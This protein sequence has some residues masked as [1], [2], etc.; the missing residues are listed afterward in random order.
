M[1][2]QDSIAQQALDK[3]L[4]EAARQGNLEEIKHLQSIGANINAEIR[5]KCALDTALESKD[6]DTIRYILDNG[7]YSDSTKSDVLY[8]AAADGNFNIVT[9][10]INEYHIRDE[11]VAHIA[12]ENGHSNIMEFMLALDPTYISRGDSC[13]NTLMHIAV[14]EN[15][16]DLVELLLSKYKPDINAIASGDNVWS[17]AIN[18]MNINIIKQLIEYN[19][20]INQ[21]VDSFYQENALHQAL[22]YDTTL[23]VAELLIL[24]GAFLS[25]YN[26]HGNAPIHLLANSDEISTEDLAKM[27]RLLVEHGA[28]IDIVN[29]KHQTARDIIKTSSEKLQAFEKASELG[30][31]ALENKKMTIVSVLEQVSKSLELPYIPKILSEIIVDYLEIIDIHHKINSIGLLG[32]SSDE[33]REWITSPGFSDKYLVSNKAKN[34]QYA[35]TQYMQDQLRKII[36][37]VLENSYI[38]KHKLINYLYN[39]D[40]LEVNGI[41]GKDYITSSKISGIKSV[42]AKHPLE[43]DKQDFRKMKLVVHPDKGGNAADFNAIDQFENKVISIRESADLSNVLAK[44]IE[45]KFKKSHTAIQKAGLYAKEADVAID[46]I[47]LYMKPNTQHVI[48]AVY[49]SAL[50]YNKLSNGLF[51]SYLVSVITP[52]SS[53]YSL[54]QGE[55]IKAGV[56]GI[57][58]YSYYALNKNIF[59]HGA[60]VFFGLNAITTAYEFYEGKYVA[61]TLQMLGVAGMYIAPTITG[62]AYAFYYTWQNAYGLYEIYEEAKHEN[63]MGFNRLI[64]D[65]VQKAIAGSD[66]P[67]F[68]HNISLAERLY[69]TCI[70]NLPGINTEYF[71]NNDKLQNHNKLVINQI[72]KITAI[73]TQIEEKLKAIT[74]TVGFTSYFT[75]EADTVAKLEMDILALLEQGKINYDKIETTIAAYK[76]QISWVYNSHAKYIN[77]VFLKLEEKILLLKQNEPEN[78]NYQCYYEQEG[79][80]TEKHEEQLKMTQISPYS[81]ANKEYCNKMQK[82]NAEKHLLKEIICEKKEYSPNNSKLHLPVKIGIDEAII[83]TLTN[84]SKNDASYYWNIAHKQKIAES[85]AELANSEQLID[86]I[87]HNIAQSYSWIVPESIVQEAVTVNHIKQTDASI[88]NYVSSVLMQGNRSLENRLQEKLKIDNEATTIVKIMSLNKEGC[89]MHGYVLDGNTEILDYELVEST[90]SELCKNEMAAYMPY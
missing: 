30:L 15:R 76:N 33:V 50:L 40:I 13:R 21:Q 10:L 47:K 9:M 67:N 78:D 23:A 26:R 3:R 75:S 64:S 42:L 45:I 27:V 4:I 65:L 84:V 1:R 28:D 19:V 88:F 81:S 74:D 41:I 86:K 90:N 89:S 11:R 48:S 8:R 17:V 56:Q 70:E 29:N 7:Q 14:K 16:E 55:Y 53:L 44:E 32:Y 46:L 35:K 58:G 61:G 79:V 34:T 20:D 6:E 62:A 37:T 87:I 71:D 12:A 39:Q 2:N 49:D 72:N 18:R 66:I 80:I 82:E 36:A 24:N 5:Y 68:L 77:E 31:Q 85:L 83:D 57:H 22:Q 52:V 54:Y 38:N 25:N 63:M 60:S 43:W 51:G 73:E 59:S 69:G